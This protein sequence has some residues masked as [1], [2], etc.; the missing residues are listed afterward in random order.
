MHMSLWSSAQWILTIFDQMDIVISVTNWLRVFKLASIIQKRS[1]RCDFWRCKVFCWCLCDGA[2]A[3][4]PLRRCIWEN[5]FVRMPLRRCLCDDAFAKV[6]LWQCL[7][8]DAFVRTPLRRYVS[9]MPFDD[10]LATMSFWWCLWDDA[11]AWW[12]SDDAFSDDWCLCDDAF[13]MMP[14]TIT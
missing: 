11:F 7:C 6:P 3:T 1:I 8:D 9:M 10:D 12:L 4:M 14:P 2:F 13:G 5:A